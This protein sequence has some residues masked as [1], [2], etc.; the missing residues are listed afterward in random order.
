MESSAHILAID[1][2]GSHIKC[3]ILNAQ[4]EGQTEYRRLPTPSA[5]SPDAVIGIILEL[6]K[7]LPDFEK[8]SVGFPGYVRNGLVYTAPNLGSTPW[9]KYDLGQQ[10]SN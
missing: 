6:V 5:A 2:G 1:V 7:G 9:V 3:I 10:V 4:G 8:V